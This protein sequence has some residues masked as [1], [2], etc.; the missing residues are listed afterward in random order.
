MWAST[1]DEYKNEIISLVV[2]IYLINMA[3]TFKCSD[4]GMQCSFAARAD[5]EDAL[6]AQIKAHAAEAHDMATIDDA[7]MAK[8][9]TAVKDEA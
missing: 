6:M 5:N 3:K 9:R 1:H 2:D 4:I 8:I 7:T